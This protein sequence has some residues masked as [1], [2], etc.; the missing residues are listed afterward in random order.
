MK[1]FNMEWTMSQKPIGMNVY[2]RLIPHKRD[3]GFITQIKQSLEKYVKVTLHKTT[4][5][6][7]KKDIPI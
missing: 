7:L 6:S 1:R 4:G 3:H 5:T 2:K